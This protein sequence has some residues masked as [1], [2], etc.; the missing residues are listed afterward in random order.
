MR[1]GEEGNMLQPRENIL[2]EVGGIRRRLMLSVPLSCNSLI[3]SN[4]RP[5]LAG[6]LASMGWILTPCPERSEP[7]RTSRSK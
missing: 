5:S 4:L 3:V 7:N 2:I 1:Y 6:R